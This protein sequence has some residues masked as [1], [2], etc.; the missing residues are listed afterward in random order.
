MAHRL[1][2]FRAVHHPTQATLVLSNGNSFLVVDTSSGKV[3]P[4]PVAQAKQ[5]QCKTLVFSPN[6]AQLATSGDD[7]VLRVYDTASWTEAFTRPVNK[8]L[9]AMRFTKDGKQIVTVD[10]FGD[11]FCHPCEAADKDDLEPIVGHVSMVT[12]LALSDDE[13]YIITSDRD[14]H[15][16]VS[17]FPN[18]YNIEA[19]CLGHTDVVTKIA[20]LPW[21]S[22]LLVS[23]GGDGSIRV[24]NFC[25]GKQQQLIDV[26]PYIE[27]HV[28]ENTDP[29]EM[30]LVQALVV[31]EK[32]QTVAVTFTRVPVVLV[33]GFD[34]GQLV[35]KQTIQVGKPV[36]DVAFDLESRLWLAVVPA[37]ENDALVA[38]YA[39]VDGKY[40]PSTDASLVAPINAT[41]VEKGKLHR[42]RQMG[43]E[44]SRACLPAFSYSGRP[45]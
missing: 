14:E 25:A 3:T 24:W 29:S 37:D 28:P 42:M 44:I 43:K 7:K 16:R 36:M 20:V 31:D 15:I 8:R 6:G 39:P 27:E 41:D 21:Q 40:E 10:K 30:P 35:H 34:N 4:S 33:F 1:P 22:N 11:A 18:G 13:K 9:N 45:P 38:L 19:F 2:F 12:D 5:D 17:R 23:A 26:M 32:S